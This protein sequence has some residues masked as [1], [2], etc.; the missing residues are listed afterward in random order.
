[1]LKMKK[2]YLFKVI[3]CILMIFNYYFVQAQN[4]KISIDVSNV[5]LKEFFSIIENKSNYNFVFRDAM[6]DGK[7]PVS[8][9]I[10][11]ETIKQILDQVLNKAK[12]KYSLQGNSILIQEQNIIKKTVTGR[13]V[14]QSGLP[15][16]GA[17]VAEKGTKNV[18][19]TQSDGSFSLTISDNT[20]LEISFIGYN[21]QIVTTSGKTN[22][23]ITL[24]E[25]SSILDE[26]VVVGYG[27][28]KK[29][30]LT[31]SIANIKA[32][33]LNQIPVANLSNSLAG[34]APGATIVGT[35][36]LIGAT[37][38]I[39]LRGGFGEPLFIID[40]VRRDKPAFDA[41]DPNEID[42][43]SFLKDA[44]TASVY[45]TAAGNGVVLVTTKEGDSKASKPIFNYQGYY[46]FSE[47]TKKLMTDRFTATDELVYQ[48]R[49]A[50]FQGRTVPNGEA[51]FA[52]FENRDYNVNDW[53]WQTPWSTKHLLSVSGGTENLQYYMLGGYVKEE[54]SFVNLENDKYNIRSNVTAKL[55]KYIKMNF[56]ISGFMKQDKRFYWPATS[57]DDYD[58]HD[59]Y[60][61][62]FNV[63]RTYPFYMHEDG[64]PANE[65]TE[66]PLY[67]N[68]G[69]WTGWNVVDQ[70]IGNR[71]LKRRDRNI[72]AILT[73]DFDLGFLVKG[74]ST[75]VMGSY[76]S[77]DQKW[78]RFLTFQK[79]YGF[80][81]KEGQSNRFVPGPIN[82]E[83][84]IIYN[85]NRTDEE[86]YYQSKQLWSEQFNWFLNYANTFGKH[87]ISA[88]AIFEQAANG[89]EYLNATARDP[90]T[91]YDQWFVFSNEAS[92]R[93]A[94]AGEYTGGRLSWIGRVNYNFNQKYIAEFSFRY[95]GS[96]KFAKGRR[97]GFFPS[98][99]AAWRINQ[100]G[101]METTRNWLSDLKLRF[102]Y[103][104]T[105]NDLDINGNK[106]G[107][108]DYLWKYE[109]V[110]NAYNYMYGGGLNKGI[111]PGTIPSPY[112]TWA[113]SK[114]Y[115]G[116][117]DFGLFRQKLTGTIDVFSRKESNILG[118][119]TESLPT[120]YGT[121]LA[122]ENYAARSWKGA[123]FALN[124]NDKVA[125]GA[126]NYSLYVNIG[127]AKD[128][129]D[130]IDESAA[131]KT[132]SLQ[133][134]S[135]V[136]MAHDRTIG[137]IA[138]D[139]IRTQEQLDNLLNKGFTQF[140]RKPYLGAILYED[141]RK[142]GYVEGQDGKI[143]ANDSYNLLSEN[144]S[145]RINYGFGG[146]VSFKGFSLALHFQGVGQYD[147]FIGGYEGGF[148]QWGGTLRPYYPIWANGDVWTK[149]NPNAK[150]P[151]V[152]GQTWQ[153]AGGTVSTLWK[154][155][156]AYLRLKNLNFAY[157]IPRKILE[158]IGIMNTQLFMNITN[159]FFISEV[160]EFH[161]PEQKNADSYPLMRTFTF[162][163]NFSF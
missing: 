62:T 129:W 44:A 159:L 117:F 70:V 9:N 94:N 147:R 76:V 36:G 100:E 148:P 113:I 11:D 45:G 57:D 37:S 131:Y 150:Y 75:K 68:Y 116:G 91:E 15:L 14:D 130:I 77:E 39:R 83:N 12:L 63:P 158:P 60:R 110:D 10:K 16:V 89:G 3:V 149:E 78:K 31:G 111:K 140:G 160:G 152:V 119:R 92:K 41:L 123:E 120:T 143:D 52:Y 46:S 87:G 20:E 22:L 138:K 139:I 141:T 30:N 122:P 72:N 18:T 56:N 54:G 74:L 93:S 26:V 19:M 153:E 59:L 67:P 58:V 64:T 145:P 154:K 157:D 32:E 112:L 137:Y 114:T 133:A 86:L 161:D 6:L 69:G 23:N 25:D 90:L 101:F 105:G 98:V 107:Q 79:N 156:G 102:S 108:Y 48:N 127:Y 115:N 118:P 17:I 33:E 88:S 55:S 121:K 97:W 65:V 51:E 28:Q 61:A 144:S 136:G 13:V 85:F 66:F 53:I 47:P 43:I 8:L 29:V 96:D 73:F 125:N 5:T 38:T 99:S 42:Q 132:G 21:S 84:V 71:Y 49:V 151:R 162:G 103:G 35:S 50:E 1:M 80:Q 142:D 135:K 104:T 40:G 24:N 81:I 124:W 4:E 163:L 109:G 128:Q 27:I 2:R 95:D 155:N 146:H 134:L 126:L 34:R 106:L 82:K 7:S